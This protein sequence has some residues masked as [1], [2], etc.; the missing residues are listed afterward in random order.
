VRWRNGSLELSLCAANPQEWLGDTLHLKISRFGRAS[1][2]RITELARKLHSGFVSRI[3]SPLLGARIL[4][5]KVM[6]ET[7]TNVMPFQ[8]VPIRL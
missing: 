2:R 5:S 6:Q 7:G 3:I 1:E 8:I 4:E